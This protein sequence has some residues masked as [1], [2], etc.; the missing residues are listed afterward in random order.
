MGETRVDL[1]HLLEDLRDAYPG[2]LEETILTE[3]IANSLDSGAHQICLQADSSESTLTI[4]DNGSGMQ[5]RD[6]SKYH[7][8]AASKK[9]RGQGI[10]FA[11]VGIKLGLLACEN[12]LT[13][14]RRGK[15][16]VSTSWHLSSRYR[17][18]WKWVP[19]VG[20]LVNQGTAVRLKLQHALSP[21]VDV[22]F[23]ESTI[24][25]HF[26]PLFDPTFTDILRSCYPHGIVFELN[27]VP[28]KCQ[29]EWKQESA[30]LEI[31]MLRKRKPSAVGY[32]I[33]SATLLPEEQQG[34][35]ISTYGK[36][37]KGGW[38][39]LG[40]TPTTPEYIGGLIE[41]PALSSS[42]TL[43]KGDFI[44]VGARGATYL[45]YRKA[46]Q[47]SVL[48]QLS[49]WG[50]T[51]ETLEETPP[52][53]MRPLERDLERV[54]ED[55]S[56]VFPLLGALVEHRK[57]GQKRLPLGEPGDK[58]D[59]RAIVTSGIISGS[60]EDP[61]SFVPPSGEPE[62]SLPPV[63][64]PED[65]SP[66]PISEENSHVLL[67]DRGGP[68]RAARF[69]L[70]IQFTHQPG[71]S[72]LGRLMESTVWIN[73]AHPAYRRAVASRS[74]GYHI[75]LA[76]A[77]ALASLAVEPKHEHE[78]VTAFLTYWGE[79]LDSKKRKTRRR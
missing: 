67:P 22:G 23:L 77:L 78:F 18:P 35:A 21:L 25:R 16:H 6:L 70:G 41:A 50:D 66:P 20:L 69:G 52:R 59:V 45:A 79:A 34:L 26:R 19:P 48:R 57:G 24:A 7:D 33:R 40:V 36:V 61:K 10:G 29:M 64:L 68:K 46:I 65:N 62:P 2:A 8:I 51:R 5:R 47:E 9:T 54:L 1:L 74:V 75:A 44:R 3:I 30:P 14:T 42:L 55:L 73:Q 58:D 49:L 15:T 56:E 11:G 37:I 72:E 27:G 12:V 31:R 17:A 60:T 32:L 63:H 71:D 53:Q 39:W 13:E 76:V 28:L 4:V 38:D 43:N